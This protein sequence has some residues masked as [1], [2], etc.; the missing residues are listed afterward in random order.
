VDKKNRKN[1]QTVKLGQLVTAGMDVEVLEK[2]GDKLVEA[3]K[4][5]LSLLESE[6]E[7]AMKN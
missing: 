7:M 5:F 3:L 1:N 4:P 6:Q 2:T